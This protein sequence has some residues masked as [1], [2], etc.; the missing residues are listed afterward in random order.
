MSSLSLLILSAL[1][2]V[3]GATAILASFALI[4]AMGMSIISGAVSFASAT[5]P[6][7]LCLMGVAYAASK[8]GFDA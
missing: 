5:L 4:G 2:A 1:G 6:A 3:A 8:T 7:A